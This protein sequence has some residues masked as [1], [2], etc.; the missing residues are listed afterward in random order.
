MNENLILL[1]NWADF[2]QRQE[3]TL[4]LIVYRELK[5]SERCCQLEWKFYFIA[6]SVHYSRANYEP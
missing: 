3:N 2:R 4:K 5:I 6:F 1:S